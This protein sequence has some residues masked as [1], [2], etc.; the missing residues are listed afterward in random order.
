MSDSNRLLFAAAAIGLIVCSLIWGVVGVGLVFSS[1]QRAQAYREI[2]DHRGGY[3]YQSYRT[4]VRLT[5]EE[6]ANASEQSGSQAEQSTQHDLCAQYI[7]ATAAR[8]SANYAQAQTWIGVF[9]F[10]FVIVGLVLNWIATLAATEQAKLARRAIAQPFLQVEPKDF[11]LAEARRVGV[12]AAIP[13]SESAK[14]VLHNHGAAPAVLIHV[15]SRLDLVE[16]GGAFPGFVRNDPVEPN[17]LVFG[18]I[19]GADKDSAGLWASRTRTPEEE[20]F[21]LSGL[22][23][24]WLHGYAVYSD[25]KDRYYALGFCYAFTGFGW[26]RSTPPGCRNGDANYH[27]EITKNPNWQA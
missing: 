27:R 22:E 10:A 21:F 11:R 18:V 6:C 1:E 13:R 4:A 9:G 23:D 16:D 17:M 5:E 20:D 7:A 19:V 26:V 24:W 12:M 2:D 3:E 14:F 15:Q 25:G 8:K